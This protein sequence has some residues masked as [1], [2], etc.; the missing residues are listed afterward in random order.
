A[1][2]EDYIRATSN[3]YNEPLFSDISINVDKSEE[4]RTDNRTC[5]CK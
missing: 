1:A 2:S 4:F 3:Y 5:F